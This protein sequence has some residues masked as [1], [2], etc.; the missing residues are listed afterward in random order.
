MRY[1]NSSL[2]QKYRAIHLEL[3]AAGIHVAEYL[4]V[5]PPQDVLERKL[6]EAISA[7]RLRFE[8]KP[9]TEML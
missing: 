4:T 1:T 2:V 5:L 3:D 9:V 8:S 7:A 6:Q